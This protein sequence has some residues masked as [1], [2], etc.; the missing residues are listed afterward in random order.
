MEKINKLST[1]L[2]IALLSGCANKSQIT[3]Y[4]T[5]ENLAATNPLSCVKAESIGPES[6]AA[7]I[8]VG[9]KA[10]LNL[11]KFDEAAELIMVASAYAY[12]DTL[13]VADNSAHGALTAIFTKHFGSIPEADKK[14]LFASIGALDN[15]PSRKSEL[16]SHL[17]SAPPP[18]YFP[19]YMIAHG[20][21]SFTN[22]TTEGPLVKDFDSSDAWSKSMVFIKCRG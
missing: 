18:S 17:S 7:D 12:F 19:N 14:E 2:S 4:E 21:G 5:I 8:T 11:S 22:S 1:L 16:C 3:N 10:C 15:N 13:R 9:A 20:M 6:T